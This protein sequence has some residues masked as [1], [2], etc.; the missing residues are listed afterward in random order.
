MT[1]QQ[2]RLSASASAQIPAGA[3]GKISVT[4]FTPYMPS[5]QQHVPSSAAIVDELFWQVASHTI[6]SLW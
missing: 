6:V 1:G 5:Q 2:T 4:V 3:A